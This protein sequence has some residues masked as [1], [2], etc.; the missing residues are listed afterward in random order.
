MPPR[1]GRR[2]LGRLPGSW[3]LAPGSRRASPS[4]ARSD[5][6]SLPVTAVARRSW[7]T[8]QGPVMPSLA[9][10][11]SVRAKPMAVRGCGVP[12]RRLLRRCSSIGRAV[13]PGGFPISHRSAKAPQ[14]P[15]KRSSGHK[16]S[17]KVKPH[18]GSQITLSA[19]SRTGVVVALRPG[20]SGSHGHPHPG[21]DMY[22]LEAESH[23]SG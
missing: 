22:P 18:P 10:C 11:G 9:R 15:G 23:A 5:G 1:A 6:S 21:L 8:A 17:L 19:M 16:D 20:Q 3:L 12:E 2:R 4:L 13:I 14:L 7:R